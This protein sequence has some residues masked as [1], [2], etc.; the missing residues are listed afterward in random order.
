MGLRNSIIIGDT[1]YKFEE[2]RGEGPSSCIKCDLKTKCDFIKGY[3]L[4]SIMD[5]GW[6]SFVKVG[7]LPKTKNDIDE[8]LPMFDKYDRIDMMVND[9]FIFNNEGDMDILKVIPSF[10]KTN[11]LKFSCLDCY[12]YDKNVKCDNILCVTCDRKDGVEVI[13]KHV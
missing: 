9:E 10:D 12:F 13:F 2:G 3:D 11:G 1:I 8:N 4:C 7:D 6:G 5:A